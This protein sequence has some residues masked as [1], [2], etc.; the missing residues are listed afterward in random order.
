[1]RPTELT[2]I[3]MSC[4]TLYSFFSP[5]GAQNQSWLRTGTSHSPGTQSVPSGL[6]P[7]VFSTVPPSLVPAL[8]VLQQG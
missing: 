5:P 8:A 7:I 2:Y 1:M 3:C 4:S 6:P